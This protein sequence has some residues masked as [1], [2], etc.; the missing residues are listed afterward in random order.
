[1]RNSRWLTLDA[2][3]LLFW[4]LAVAYLGPI[5]AFRYFPTQDGP[6]HLASSIILKDYGQEG[7]RY[8]EFFEVRAE[9]LPNWT[10]HLLLAGLMLIV[11]PLVAE[12]LLLSLYVLTFGG[13]L[14]YF[15]AAFGPNTR[16]CALVGLLF[17]YHRGL[18]LG[19]YNWDLSL[20]LALFVFGFWLWHRDHADLFTAAAL[21]LLLMLTFFTHLVGFIS[22]V[23]GL[24]WFALTSPRQRWHN[25]GWAAL[26]TVPAGLLTLDYL[27]RTDF[28][29]AGG[30]GGMWQQISPWFAGQGSW[31][32]LWHDLTLLDR[33]YF[34]QHIQG[35]LPM[36]WIA[37]SLLSLLVV[38]TIAV[39]VMHKPPMNLKIGP[40]PRW[41]AALL[42]FGFLM[43]Y[44]L[45]PDNLGEHGSFLKTRLALLPPLLFLGSLALPT[46]PAVRGAGHAGVVCTG[47]QSGSGH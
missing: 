9:P 22:A 32:R 30:A 5:W 3:T 42:A 35:V 4:A 14:R 38:A 27:D 18:W 39:F 20:V 2:E 15:C 31:E 23:L 28:F 26:A 1:M 16:P 29:T 6:V 47:R 10:A 19:F 11:P 46:L 21:S 36:G 43:I 37:L 24:G 40:V 25:L 34:G 33:E 7:T 12:K 17:T 13:A 45:I 41:P 44:I 8:H